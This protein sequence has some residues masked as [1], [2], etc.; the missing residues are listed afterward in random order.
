M[1]INTFSTITQPKSLLLKLFSELFINIAFQKASLKES[2]SIRLIS[3][4]TIEIQIIIL[5][6]MAKYFTISQ[7]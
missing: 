7:F 5:R 1:N 3:I 6:I 2:Y 4:F